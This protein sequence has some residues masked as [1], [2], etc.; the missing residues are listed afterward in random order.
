MDRHFYLD[1]IYWPNTDLPAMS[2]V[3]LE[4]EI[5]AVTIFTVDSS[6]VNDLLAEHSSLNKILRILAYCFRFL[7]TNRARFKETF[8]SHIEMR[9]ALDIIC[10]NVQRETFP[11]EYKQLNDGDQISNSSNI[12]SLTPFLDERGL[13]RVGGRLRRSD[14]SYEARHPILLPRKHKLTELIIRYEHIHNLHAGL[15]GTIS[16]IRARFWP[17]S[18]RSTVRRII[19][20]CVTCFK[21]KPSMSQAIMGDLPR[22]RVIA[23]RP[24]SHT[25]V[26]YAGPIFL[27]DSK[28]RNAKIVKAYVALFVC[29]AT[30][31]VHIEIVSD[32][33]SQAFLGAFKRFMSRRGKPIAMYSDNGTTFVGAQK[34]MKE[35]REFL[36]D[37]KLKCEFR[38]FLRDNETVWHFIP[39][40]APH[41]GGLW[42]AA[43]KSAK[44]HLHRIVGSANLTFE[45]MQTVLCEIESILNSRP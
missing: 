33:T 2:N 26:D 11:V 32:L 31:A 24:F 5:V 36:E 16:A 1:E 8:V 7:P 20:N 41:F 27:K 30:K 4:E 14:A 23:S 17:L 15:Q 34:C 40:H 21:C 18:M 38:E 10:R 43:V 19:R 45:E 12:L 25:G 28:R 3:S 22:N 37:R 39:P 42:K 9:S 29:F 6:I 44:M 35:F 13:I